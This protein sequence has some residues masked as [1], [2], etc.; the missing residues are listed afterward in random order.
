[1]MKSSTLRWSFGSIHWSGLK[2]PPEPSPRG[3]TQAIW[4][5]R[6]ETSNVAI[7][8]APLSPFRIRFQVGSMPQPSG[9]TMPR[10]VT[11]TRL[12]QI[13]PA[14]CTRSPIT[15]SG[16]VRPR[17]LPLSQARA[18]ASALRVLFQKFGRIADGQDRLGGVIGN[19]TTEF[20]FESHHELDRVE[21][22]SAEVVNKAR[23][24]D[25]LFGLNTKVFDHDLLNPLANLTHRSTS[26]CSIGPTQDVRAIVVVNFIRN[27]AQS[28]GQSR[29]IRT[30][31]TM[32]GSASPIYRVSSSC[33]GVLCPSLAFGYHTSKALTTSL[34]LRPGGV[35]PRHGRLKSSL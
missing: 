10:P 18:G 19:L 22:V 1:M 6:S 21:T 24:V 29:P 17:S 9:E 34:N 28:L 13:T 11:T 3:T 30:R 12:I 5:A 7:F 14:S 15:N 33:N 27:R 2:V 23:V 20:F 32:T 8:R 25:N 26:C 35:S 4:L 16:T 31:R